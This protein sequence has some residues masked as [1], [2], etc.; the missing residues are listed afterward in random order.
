MPEVFRVPEVSEQLLVSEHTV[1]AML[2][3]GTLQGFRDG[4]LIRITRASVEALIHKRSTLE[5]GT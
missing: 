5:P 3:R 4:R 2:R 1:R